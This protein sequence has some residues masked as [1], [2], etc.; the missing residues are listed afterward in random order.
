M[1]FHCVRLSKA[2]FNIIAMLWMCHVTVV[3]FFDHVLMLASSHR[4]HFDIPVVAV[5]WKWPNL[6]DPDVGGLR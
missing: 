3:N 5:I 6:Y 4:L 1:F 2:S